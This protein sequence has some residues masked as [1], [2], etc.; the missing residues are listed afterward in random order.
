MSMKHAQSQMPYLNTQNH[1]QMTFEHA[2]SQNN[3]S[4]DKLSRWH[5]GLEE[6]E[7][8]A[9]NTCMQIPG[10]RF[11]SKWQIDQIFYDILQKY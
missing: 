9:V 5:L 11:R 8:G 2:V 4:R 3:L 7:R 10:G 6:Q 1:V